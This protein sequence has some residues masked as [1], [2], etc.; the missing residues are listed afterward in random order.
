[1]SLFV[2]MCLFVVFAVA[3][4]FVVCDSVPASCFNVCDLSVV[5]SFFLCSDVSLL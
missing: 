1:M 5:V 4:V 3:F 2:V